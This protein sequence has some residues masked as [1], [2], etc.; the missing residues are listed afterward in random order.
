MTTK[1]IPSVN[2]GQMKTI[3]FVI[4]I[5]IIGYAA[6]V[7]LQRLGL[8]RSK[9]EKSAAKEKD[10][11][12]AEKAVIEKTILTSDLL[13]PNYQNTSGVRQVDLLSDLLAE[14]YARKIHDAMGKIPILNIIT[15]NV[16]DAIGVIQQLYY[17]P[18]ISQIAEKFY[19]IYGLSFASTLQDYF[20]KE[21][22]IKIYDTINKLPKK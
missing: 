12:T 8:I 4:T 11:T 16:N 15:S 17:A 9:G 1:N 2:T 22:L 14:K 21:D 5:I 3:A 20:S 19:N 7:I 6:Y 18:Q 10:K 13:N